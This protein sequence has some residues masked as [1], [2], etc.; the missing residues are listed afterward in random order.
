MTAADALSPRGPLGPGAENPTAQ[1]PLK[2]GWPGGRKQGGSGSA[3]EAGGPAGA[4]SRGAGP[5]DKPATAWLWGSGTGSAGLLKGIFIAAYTAIFPLGLVGLWVPAGHRH[6]L[7]MTAYVALFALGTWAWRHELARMIRP[8]AARKLRSVG[9]LLLGLIGMAVIET[10]GS[11][12]QMLLQGLLP[13]ANEPLGNDTAIS[14]LTGLYPPL[15]LAV[16]LGVLGPVVE[17]LVFR[18]VL[19]PVI[20]HRA[21]GW[22]AV[23]VSSVLFGMLHMESFAISEWVGVIP[24]ACFGLALGILFLRTRGNLLYPVVLHVLMNLSAFL[25][26]Q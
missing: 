7:L 14:A 2:R 16:V 20:S 19:I 25:T 24:H 11:L 6:P 12:L 15:V 13:A 4:P 5:G 23:V 17:E 26:P 1:P 8:I 3:H 21:P 10:L 9:I 18:Q 22:V